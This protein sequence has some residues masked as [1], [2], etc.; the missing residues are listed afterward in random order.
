M[1]GRR[2]RRIIRR[3]AYR[4][5]HQRR[6]RPSPPLPTL[7][8]SGRSRWTGRSS[9]GRLLRLPADRVEGIKQDPYYQHDLLFSP[10]YRTS[11]RPGPHRRHL[12]SN[13]PPTRILTATSHQRLF[14]TPPLLPLRFHAYTSPH[15]IHPHH[16][17]CLLL[18]FRA[19]RWSR[20]RYASLC[21]SSI[22]IHFVFLY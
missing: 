12:L 2:V 13:I 18:T 4:T 19:T 20:L 17:P 15:P 14:S 11:T 5:A 6:R 7:R 22:Y 3:P 21:I 1:L 8:N 16:Y 9:E 10:L